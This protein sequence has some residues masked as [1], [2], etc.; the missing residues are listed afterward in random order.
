MTSELF[1]IFLKVLRNFFIFWD[2]LRLL[3]ALLFVLSGSDKVPEGSEGFFDILGVSRG[4]Q[5]L[6]EAF[7]WITSSSE[8]FQK[9]LKHTVTFSGGILRCSHGL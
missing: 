1:K 6:S 7:S 2:V 3:R 5:S 8:R 9:I 4:F